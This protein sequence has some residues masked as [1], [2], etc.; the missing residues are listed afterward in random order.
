MEG[1][2][3]VQ[4]IETMPCLGEEL[5]NMDPHWKEAQVFYQLE[6]N[7]TRTASSPTPTGGP[8]SAKSEGLS[9]S[10]GG[11]RK[12]VGWKAIVGSVLVLKVISLEWFI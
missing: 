5:L 12:R 11:E 8:T 10:S 9:S 2:P 3:R 6:Q 4:E 7:S 1:Q